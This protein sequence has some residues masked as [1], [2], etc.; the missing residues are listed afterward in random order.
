MSYTITTGN[1][2]HSWVPHVNKSLTPTSDL[3][4]MIRNG[5]GNTPRNQLP[6]DWRT[7]QNKPERRGWAKKKGS[8]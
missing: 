4:L 3:D 2:Q 5:W 8:L 6:P 1:G 7:R